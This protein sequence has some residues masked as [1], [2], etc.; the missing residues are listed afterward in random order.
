MADKDDLLIKLLLRKLYEL[1][2]R[3]Q[4]RNYAKGHSFEEWK[5]YF[6]GCLK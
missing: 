6:A 4:N 3:Q 2:C 5:R 1:E